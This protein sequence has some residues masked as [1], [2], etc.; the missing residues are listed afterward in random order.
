MSNDKTSMAGK[1]TY[2]EIERSLERERAN[3]DSLRAENTRLNSML[4]LSQREKAACA[5][6]RDQAR[7]ERDAAYAHI[8][9]TKHAPAWGLA[10]GA[11]LTGLV[12]AGK[13]R[14]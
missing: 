14:P 9:S 12:L 5:A 10:I 11:V 13:S 8:E 1:P 6:E 3:V 2:A 7:A 4:A